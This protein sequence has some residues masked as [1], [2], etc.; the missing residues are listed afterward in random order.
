MN[1][2]I[3]HCYLCPT[4][5]HFKVLADP[6]WTKMWRK[7]GYCKD[8]KEDVRQDPGRGLRN[9]GQECDAYKRGKR[10]IANRK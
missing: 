3:Y 1:F 5:K 4:C 7:M 2:R 6:D 9:P 8:F 10:G